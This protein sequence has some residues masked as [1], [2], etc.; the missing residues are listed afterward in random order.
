MMVRRIALGLV[1]F[2]V[3]CM[4]AGYFDFVARPVELVGLVAGGV[5]LLTLWFTRDRER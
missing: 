1:G 2:W 5:G 4:I 3:A